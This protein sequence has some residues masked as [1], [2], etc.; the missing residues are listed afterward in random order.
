[1]DAVS[2]EPVSDPNEARRKR[3]RK[4]PPEA[5]DN[6]ASEDVVMSDAPTSPVRLPLERVIVI[7]PEKPKP[8]PPPLSLSTKKKEENRSKKVHPFFTGGVKPVKDPSDNPPSHSSPPPPNR[9]SPRPAWTGFQREEKSGSS[10]FGGSLS[11]R[12][13]KVLKIPGLLDAPWPTKEQQHVRG[14]N[15]SHH[16]DFKRNPTSSRASKQKSRRVEVTGGDDIL[17]GLS[18]KLRVN[19]LKEYISRPEY[20]QEEY[21]RVCDNIHVPERLLLTGKELQAQV[22]KKIRSPLPEPGDICRR[23]RIERTASASSMDSASSDSLVLV[24]PN[25]KPHPAILQ[26]YLDLRN[27]VCAFESGTCE[28]Q[29]WNNKYAP[30][31]S[32][33]VLQN[34]KNMNLLRGWL[35]QL[36][37][38]SVETAESAIARAEKKKKEKAKA[39][40]EAARKK[41]K[42]N[43]DDLDGFLAD[44]DDAKTL[45]ELTDPEDDGS[46][47]SLG[48]AP[49][50]S[51]HRLQFGQ[52]SIKVPKGNNAISNV[53]LISGPS[54]CGK[55]A[56][57]Y[58]VAKELGYT[59]FEVN[60]GNRR[61]GK[62][63]L[64]QVGQMSKNHLVHQTKELVKEKNP[65]A[66]SKQS[67][68]QG[69][70]ETKPCA[71]QQQSLILFEEVDLLFEEDKQFWSTVQQLAMDSKRPV[72]LTCNDESLVPVD[73]LPLQ[74]LLRFEA[75]ALELAA[76]Y[77]LLIAANEG[78]ILE[79][80][81][82]EVLYQSSHFDLRHSIAQLQFWCQMSVGDRRSGIDW[83]NVERL[84]ISPTRE[85]K[86]VISKGAFRKGLNLLDCLNK[87]D[88]LP[89]DELWADIWNQF[90]F[91][92]GGED[93]GMSREMQEW[94]SNLNVAAKLP[95]LDAYCAYTDA[96]SAA[97]VFT[98]DGMRCI[99]DAVLE[100]SNPKVTESVVADEIQGFVHLHDV[101]RR[102]PT[103]AFN[104]RLGT[105]VRSLA[106]KALQVNTN[107]LITNPKACL[108][109][110][111]HNLLISTIANA[112]FV[113]WPMM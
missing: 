112:D 87:P 57:I 16:T 27:S 5:K 34:E 40:L 88:T 53:I 83:V 10:S 90:E 31:T 106:R 60:A 97:D 35:E 86:R 110:I 82:T 65:F 99:E 93:I 67:K 2:T 61:S 37:V 59:V 62:D 74:A 95:S 102:R 32:R 91:D 96:L 44:S 17:A 54:G 6:G 11:P 33:E 51:N 70:K 108:P 72:I 24:I 50:P 12:S 64:D 30:K 4:S 29:A 92:A 76:D 75:P 98:L 38:E 58:A 103:T 39:K 19:E 22:R 36:R 113:R 49:P 14:Y 41:K 18:R 23:P 79:R 21:F 71:Q 45:D 101:L 105:S 73:T 100:V 8:A 69:D 66:I 55:T 109:D 56:A 104:T 42:R 80:S 25:R 84:S 52:K 7:S 46:V 26:L 20:A 1:M 28:T 68:A 78:H 77:L 63:I 15:E 89:E 43:R 48:F 85:V 81:S 47:V 94:S 13:T 3:R 111:S 9:P 107:D